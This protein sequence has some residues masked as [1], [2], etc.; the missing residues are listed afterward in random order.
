[1]SSFSEI[2]VSTGVKGE[3]IICGKNGI[4]RAT[5]DRCGKQACHRE[6]CIRL[7]T[8]PG[9]CAVPIEKERGKRGNDNT[10]DKLTAWKWLG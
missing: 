3:C 8:E 5:C 9:Q 1:M 7:I 6:R 2:V 4:L 10:G